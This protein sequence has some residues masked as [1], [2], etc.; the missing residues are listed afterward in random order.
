MAQ[1]EP[2]PDNP[3]QHPLATEP[4]TKP[5]PSPLTAAELG[6]RFI[7]PRTGKAISARAI[8]IALQQSDPQSFKDYCRQR[9]PDG[10]AWKFN[11]KDKLFVCLG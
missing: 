1:P 5:L 11:K 3:D 7:S 6:Q 2:V 10:Y 4:P 9:D 8:Q